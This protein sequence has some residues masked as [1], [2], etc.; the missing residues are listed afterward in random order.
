LTFSIN[1]LGNA[2]D[3]IGFSYKETWHNIKTSTLIGVDIA[4]GGFTRLGAGIKLFANKALLAISEVPIIGKSID[5]KNL[6]K[7]FHSSGTSGK[8]KSKVLT[9]S[10]NVSPSG[11]PNAIA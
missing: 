11:K 5:K 4:V 1:F 2:I 3:A 10:S 8:A 7:T 6:S 9:A